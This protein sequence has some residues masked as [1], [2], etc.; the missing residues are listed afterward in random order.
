MISEAE[1]EMSVSFL[2][3]ALSVNFTLFDQAMTTGVTAEQ[4]L[5]PG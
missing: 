3:Q 2:F 1:V 4:L 5:S